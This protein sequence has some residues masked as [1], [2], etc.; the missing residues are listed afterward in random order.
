MKSVTEFQRFKQE[1]QPISMVT[2]YDAWSARLIAASPIDAVLVGDSVAMVMHGQPSTVHATIE[3][4]AS[5]TAA[6]A[7]GVGNKF[8]VA[9]LPFP[10]HRMGRETAMRA[11][12]AVMKAGA[13]AV[14][15]EGVR[16]HAEIVARGERRAGDGT[17]R[18]HPTEC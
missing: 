12:D 2:S 13:H 18:P 10:L 17:S 1:G 9:D 11:V 16:G 3:M 4:M 6:V 14:K 7:R 5:H 8:L 15:L